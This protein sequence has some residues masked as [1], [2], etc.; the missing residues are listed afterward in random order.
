MKGGTYGVVMDSR[1]RIEHGS[2]IDGD[3]DCLDADA[4]TCGGGGIVFDMMAD[5]GS[6]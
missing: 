2:V 6:G 5:V 4:T 3:L 1:D